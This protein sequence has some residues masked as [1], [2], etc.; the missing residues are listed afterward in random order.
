MTQKFRLLAALTVLGL[1]GAC[2]TKPK[3]EATSTVEEIPNEPGSGPAAPAAETPLVELAPP[4]GFKVQMPANPKVDRKQSPTPSGNVAVGS[5][6]T[7]TPEGVTFSV[8]TADYPESI[9]ASISPTNFLNSV[10]D[11]VVKQLQGTVKSEEE[12]TLDGYPG[13]A[14]V[15]ESS[16]GEVKVRNYLVGPRLYTLLVVYNPSIGAPQADTFLGSLQLVNPP[17]AVPFRGKGSAAADGGTETLGA[18]AGTPADA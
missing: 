14:F 16:Q 6:A 4:E 10:R 7:Q 2:A 8:S 18:D 15:V 5:W 11:G 3:G 17:P 13:K 1:V 12:I 9:I